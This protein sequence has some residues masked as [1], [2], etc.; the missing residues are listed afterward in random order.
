MKKLNDIILIILICLCTASAISN[1]VTL[2]V[3][4]AGTSRITPRFARR[5]VLQ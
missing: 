5:E 3:R 2:R 1:T 4:R